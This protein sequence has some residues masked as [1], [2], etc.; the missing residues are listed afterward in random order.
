MDVLITGGAR[1][2]GRATALAFAA[3]GARL[4]LNYLGNADGAAEAAR[5]CRE[6][7]SPEVLLL[8]GDVGCGDE[9][10][11]FVGTVADAWGRLDVVFNNAG[12]GQPGKLEELTEEQWDRCFDTHVKGAFHV[13][14]ATLPLLRQGQQK[15]IINTGSVAGLRGLPKM[16]VYGCV[17]ATLHQFTRCLA[18][19]LADEGIR[20]NAICPGI[21]RTDF[22]AAMSPEAYEHNVT[23]RIPLH[24]EGQPEDIAQ[25]VL[26]MV[27][28]QYLTG[29]TVTVDGGLTMR[30]C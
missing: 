21:I 10:K 15:V 1:G 13:C 7:G 25:M 6:A 2:I 30:I 5:L 23:N 9:V 26:A 27:D 4:G 19:E 29:E 3:R 28:N 18:W 22:H 20:V 8:P 11:R 24:R 12:Y 14:R 16:I 17:K